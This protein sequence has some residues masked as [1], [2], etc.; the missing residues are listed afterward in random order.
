[1]PGGRFLKKRWAYIV[2]ASFFFYGWWDWRFLLLLIFSGLIDYAAAL[3]M[4]WR[5]DWKKQLLIFSLAGNIGSLAVFKYSGFVASNLDALLGWLG[6]SVGLYARVPEFTLILPV[7]ISFYTFQSMS[8]TIDVW[9]GKL[10]PTKNILHFFSY[11]AFFPQLVAG[12]IIRATDLL[13]QLKE[14][15]RTSEE[16]RWE[17]VK[18]MI[19]GFFK[20]MVLADNLAPFVT[21]AFAV[22]NSLPSAPYWWLAASAFGLQIYFDFSGY[23][24]I[25]IGLGRLLGYRFKTNFNHPYVS[26]SL[27]EFWSR[28]HISLST[29]FRDYVYIPLGGNRQGALASYAF[30]SVTFISSGLWHGAAWTFVIWSAL[31]ALFISLEKL[32][33]WPARL[34]RLY[35]G[36]Q[37]VWF[38]IM[39]Q[40]TLAWVFFRAESFSQAL[41]IVKRMFWSSLNF[42]VLDSVFISIFTIGILFE[43]GVLLL[44]RLK[45]PIPAL[46]LA[47]E[48]SILAL[49]ITATI[50]FRGLPQEFIYFQ[51]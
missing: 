12:P 43:A 33:G 26:T 38:L 13:P 45:I 23:S 8:Y 7:G 42:S 32:T 21:Q 3:G 22:G 1:M 9:R 24:D 39:A 11:L 51:F 4:R 40:V 37:I 41:A 35:G 34:R 25:A 14:V 30:L 10:E 5:P 31:H 20:K 6:F 50:F 29:W 17:G 28:W 2:A 36:R 18:F 27:Q 44:P 19:L 15:P 16:D 47:A 46:K 48:I 49:L